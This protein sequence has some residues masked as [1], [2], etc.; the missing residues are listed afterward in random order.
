MKDLFYMGGPA[1][2]GTLTVIL[3]LM[4]AWAVYHFLPVFLKKEVNFAKTR[5]KLKHIK[6]IGTF[7]LVTGI[8]GQLIGFYFAF[9]A[10]EVAGDISPS[11]V[12]GGLKV[13]MITTLYGIFIYLLSLLLWLI[14]DYIA[15]KKSE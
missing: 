1:F 8:L 5:S 3:I 12:M 11:L 9:A 13:S 10:I 4:V 14:F 6:T 2:M 7:A 15:T